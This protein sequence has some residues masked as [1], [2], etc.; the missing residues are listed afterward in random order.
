[1]TRISRRVKPIDRNSPLV[2][3]IFSLHGDSQQRSPRVT[4]HID[5]CLEL[6]RVNAMLDATLKK[7]ETEL[8]EMEVRRQ[9]IQELS[10]LQR[11][12]PSNEVFSLK[13]LTP[14]KMIFHICTVFSSAV[15]DIVFI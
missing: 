2:E 11:F 15:T 3:E 7:H 6:E 14:L 12:W 4:K 13:F 10:K 1:M 5:D 8:H 9:A